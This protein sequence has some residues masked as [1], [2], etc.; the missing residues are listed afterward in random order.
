MALTPEEESV[1]DEVAARDNAGG[2][3]VRL[4]GSDGARE[5]NPALG[6]VRAALF[7]DRD[8]AVEPRLALGAL[9]E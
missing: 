5:V 2:R 8:A 9:R 4:L 7:C 6:K 3:G 1:L